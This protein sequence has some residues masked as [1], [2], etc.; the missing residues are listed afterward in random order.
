MKPNKIFQPQQITVKRSEINFAE[1]NPRHISD[2]AR[3]QLKQNLVRIGLLGGIVW[4][5]RTG[6]LISGHQR[7]AIMDSV[8][9]YNPETHENDYEFRVEVVDF[10]EKTEKEQN[11][12]MNNRNV[13]GEY[14]EDLLREMLKGVDYTL[15][16]FDDFTMQ[17]LGLES[18][19]DVTSDYNQAVMGDDPEAVD[20]RGDWNKGDV[21][22]ADSNLAMHD[23]FTQSEG[24]NTRVDRSADFYQDS[25]ANQI[26]RHNEVQK[27]KDRIANQNDSEKD[28]GALSYFVVSF[29]TPTEKEKFLDQ[30]GF[31]PTAKYISGDDLLN[32]LEF[33]VDDE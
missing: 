12:F 10:D 15:A 17:M 19:D 8:N 9:R 33:G 31:D 28:G 16:G 32:V 26:A 5:K 22:G 20:E 7:V 11:L 6:N 13:Q 27:I 3:K 29:K 30:Y 2:E 18:F 24:E 23:E 4:N 14:D 25:A 21:I 1:Y